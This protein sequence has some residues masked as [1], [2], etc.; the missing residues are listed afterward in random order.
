MQLPT[1]PQPL[2]PLLAHTQHTLAS[3]SH[4]RPVDPHQPPVAL[5]LLADLLRD[6]V[7]EPDLLQLS[8]PVLGQ[9][10]GISPPVAKNFFYNFENST[11]RRDV[12][13]R[14]TFLLQETRLSYIFQPKNVGLRVT[15][16]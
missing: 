11:K 12:Q 9:L 1:S 15:T 13:I 8:V 5:R 10:Q 4:P 2:P 3:G 14:K 16:L 7:L 6:P